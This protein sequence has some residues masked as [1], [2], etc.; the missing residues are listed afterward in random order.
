MFKIK[1]LS[2]ALLALFVTSCD[3]VSNDKTSVSESSLN[4]A[5]PSQPIEFETEVTYKNLDKDTY[6]NKT[7]GGLLGQFA[8]FLSGYEFASSTNPTGLPLGWFDFLNGPYAGNYSHFTPSATYKYDRLKVNPDT[9]L[10]EV[11]SDDDFHID[12]L[13]QYILKELGSSS[14]AIKET[15]KKYSVSDWGGGVDAMMLIGSKDLLAPFTGTIEAG[16]RYGWCT[17]A[18]IENETLGM[19]A[20]G[21]PNLAT[22]LV[23]K[24]ASNVGYFDSV[25]WAK[26]YAAMYSFGYF[27]DDVKVI[28]D[29]ALRVMP[30][31]S[32]P[33]KTYQ[34]ALSTYAQ[35]PN[36]YKTAAYKLHESRRNL[37]RIDNFQTDPNVNG[38][39]AIL[40]WLY[41]NNDYMETAKY[42]SVMG[43]D[44]DCTAAICLGMMG[45]LK[46]FKSENQEYAKIN[47]E[48]YHDGE[49]MYHNDKSTDYQARIL[50]DDYPETQKI[51]EIIDMYRDNFETLLLEQGGEI[52][53]DHYRIPTTDLFEDH[54]F[55]FKNYDAEERDISGFKS[56]DGTFECLTE[57]EN[58]NSHTGFG[59]F[60]LQNQ[61]NG[62]VY[63]RYTLQKDHFYRLNTFVKTNA[64]AQ[65]EVF[66]KDSVNGINQSISFANAQS[67]IAK[68]FTF[69]ATN[70]VMEVGF[71]FDDK[72]KDTDY[73]I[74]DDF[75]L[76]EIEYKNY[77]FVTTQELQ[78]F[79]KKYSKI[80]QKPEGV[81]VGKE[82][83]LKIE[84]RQYSGSPLFVNLIRNGKNYGSVVM[85]NTSKSS[86]SG[87]DFV[88][89][90]YIFEKDS[91]TVQLDFNGAK[92]YLGTIE[93]MKQRQYMFR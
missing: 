86:I 78:L 33:Y 31:D 8:G 6:W 79:S 9:G 20:P 27:Y 68:S 41:G 28:M 89:F 65:V 47:S 35:Y 43:Y 25:I 85:S 93:V 21:M 14:Y 24:F 71:R 62:K 92:V 37:Y 82:V 57:T 55:L 69:K 2:L 11:W 63:H 59:Y 70:S 40:S 16:N 73:V 83:T 22:Q 29:K 5:T 23:D 15:W 66:A 87:S 52:L 19:N 54:S 67:L 48:L 60:K 72:A 38:G 1:F 64:N 4:P 13:N 3:G 7:L 56:T 91:D 49:G 84:Y 88:E 74:F 51:D 61:N 77:S 36:D 34:L 46:G 30:K 44:G 50:S 10:S 18:Y 75:M 26:Y 17:E 39:L 12:I 80:I 42:S 53:E 58:G 90:P 45:I 32:Y 81:P 76:E